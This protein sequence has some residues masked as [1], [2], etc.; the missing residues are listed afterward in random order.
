VL[1]LVLKYCRHLGNPQR[2]GPVGCLR[3]LPH[4]GARAVASRPRIPMRPSLALMA[5]CHKMAQA[6][7]LWGTTLVRPALPLDDIKVI[8]MIFQ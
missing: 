2:I 7:P 3:P 4:L 1:A 5:C 8:H 6:Y